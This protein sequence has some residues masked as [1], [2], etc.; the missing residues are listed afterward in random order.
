MKTFL[1]LLCAATV[2]LA[3]V[4]LCAQAQSGSSS[5]FGDTPP[6]LSPQE[7]FQGS[8]AVQGDALAM[9][10]QIEDGY[11]LYRD[12]FSIQANELTLGEPQWPEAL[13]TK[14]DYFGEQAIFRDFFSAPV[15]ITAASAQ[16]TTVDVT[17][18]GCADIGVFRA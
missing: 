7:A 11:Y 15:P 6:L 8:V 1:P 2:A 9:S 14:D 17:F 13:I 10:F 3:S 4:S 12:K 18:Q 5:I 16:N